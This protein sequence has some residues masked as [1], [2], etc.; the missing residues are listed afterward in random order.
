M[1]GT[2]RHGLSGGM[3]RPLKES[4][5][6]VHCKVF[7]TWVL[8]LVI[9]GYIN[10]SKLDE[11]LPM[12]VGVLSRVALGEG[13]KVQSFPEGLRVSITSERD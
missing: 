1:I 5:L 6:L 7:K 8:N 3:C 10:P 2:Q 11:L 9:R 13:K 12:G 4:S